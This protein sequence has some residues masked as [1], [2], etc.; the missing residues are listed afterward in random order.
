MSS[1]HPVTFSRR[2][3]SVFWTSKWCN[4]H[5]SPRLLPVT[6][7]R[8]VVQRRTAFHVWDVLGETAWPGTAPAR[9]ACPAP[10]APAAS[11]R[12]AGR[13]PWPRAPSPA[14]ASPPP[15]LRWR[16]AAA[17]GSAPAPASWWPPPPA[18]CHTQN[19][20]VKAWFRR[21][22]ASNSAA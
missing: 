1:H 15:S 13:S 14:P 5:H 6:Q 4:E 20:T 3:V 8:L 22:A 10:A 18:T 17:G 21:W 2:V 16:V 12:P 9:P 19:D 11:W 7:R